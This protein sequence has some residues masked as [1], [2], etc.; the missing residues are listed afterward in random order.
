M[1]GT[2]IART[3]VAELKKKISHAEEKKKE[4]SDYLKNL[5]QKYRNGEISYSTFLEHFYLKRSGLNLNEWLGHFDEHIKECNKQIRKERIKLLGNY[6]AFAFL[7]LFFIS[8]LFLAFSNV[9]INF[10]GFAI[11]EGEN[12]SANESYSEANLG[13][14][15]NASPHQIGQEPLPP[16]EAN[17]SSEINITEFIGNATEQNKTG[18]NQT[19]INETQDIPTENFTTNETIL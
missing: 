15:Q 8:I 6:S 12:V 16:S 11:Q 10:T 9:K 1:G 2:R 13:E 17:L 19:Q 18:M 7:S 3:R 4:F 5:K 14:V